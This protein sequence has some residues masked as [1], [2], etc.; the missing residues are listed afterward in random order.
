MLT[1]AALP[2]HFCRYDRQNRVTFWPVGDIAHSFAS[3]LNHFVPKPRGVIPGKTLLPWRG[4]LPFINS[5]S[6]PSPLRILFALACG[7]IIGHSLSA[8][9]SGYLYNLDIFASS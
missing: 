1:I 4:D 2:P 7:I 3:R 6:L 8:L 5:T 9:G